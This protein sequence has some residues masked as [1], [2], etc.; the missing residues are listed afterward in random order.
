MTQLEQMDL[1]AEVER[2]RKENTASEVI[3]VKNLTA[4][5]NKLERDSALIK[6][7]IMQGIRGEATFLADTLNEMLQ[8]NQEKRQQAEAQL[9]QARQELQQ[10]E[11]EQTDLLELQSM[12]PKWREEFAE[13]D[14]D[15]KKVMLSKIINKITVTP[16]GV[17]VDLTLTFQQFFSGGDGS[18]TPPDGDG[19]PGDGGGESP[20]ISGEKVTTDLINPRPHRRG[21]GG[22]PAHFTG[23]HVRRR[24]HLRLHRPSPQIGADV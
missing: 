11:I 20:A 22:Q 13:A 4:N 2:I 23:Y 1:A 12:I 15:V 9:A 5:L 6:E 19:G 8:E 17:E 16:D 7:K 3:K 18:P 10:K 14:L 21:Q 24:Q